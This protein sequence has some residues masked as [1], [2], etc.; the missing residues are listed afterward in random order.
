[1][2]CECCGWHGVPFYLDA[3]CAR[4]GDFSDFF[5]TVFNSGFGIKTGEVETDERMDSNSLRKSR[6]C[7]LV[8]M[9]GGNRRSVKS[10][11]QFMSSP[12]FVAS[13]TN[14]APSID[15]STPII[16]PSPRTSRM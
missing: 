10:C 5:A 1:R 9:N 11:V 7:A 4:R 3:E 8:T 12:R 2:V 15:N 6:T 16:R 14:G 13:A